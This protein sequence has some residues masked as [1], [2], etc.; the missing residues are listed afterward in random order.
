MTTTSDTAGLLGLVPVESVP[1]SDDS[2]SDILRALLK[3]VKRV[4]DTPLRA[5]G[6][7]R[8]SSV[9][10][11]EQGT[12]LEDQETRIHEYIQAQGW[13]EVSILAD[14]AQSGRTSNR[15]G[16]RRVERLVRRRKVDVVIVDRIDRISRNLF[17]LLRFIK[18]LNDHGVT[19]VSLRENVDF[20]TAWGQLVLYILGS[21]AEFYSSILAQEIR[22][23]RYYAAKAG[24]LSSTFRLGYCKGN[25]SECT[26]PNGPGYCPAFGGPNRGGAKIRVDHPVEREAVRLMFEWYAGGDC[27]DDDIARRLNAEV[28]VLPD[29]TEVRFRTKGVPGLH[30]PGPFDRDSVRTVLNNPIY[31]GFVTYAGSDGQGNKRRK[32]V[33][34]FAGLHPSIVELALFRRVQTIRCNRYH[35]SQSRRTN[36][37]TYPLSGLVFC[38]EYRRP[39]RGIS[40]EG[41]RFRYYSDKLCR[42]KLPKSEWHQPNVRAES[43]EEAVE[44]LVTQI[45]LPSAWR[46]RILAYLLYDEGTAEMEYEKFAIRDRLRRAVELYDAGYYTREQLARIDAECQRDLA[47]LVPTN[48]YAGQEAGALLENLPSLW[49]ALADEEKNSLYRLLLNGVYLRDK[50]IEGIESR[51]PF[52]Q[53]LAEAAARW[54]ERE[55]G[56]GVP[57]V[58]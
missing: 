50:T 4:T 52:R 12:S 48:T 38:A 41:G 35:R 29:G 14:P 8:V 46:E 47:D 28:F 32:P 37:R 27:S 25:C 5:V 17:A 34:I 39:M 45:Q 42:Q 2:V 11:L 53:I 21:L 3:G 44:A 55:G 56:D 15:P 30:P 16:L 36:A 7:T 6:M 20:S 9:M 26:D 33:E 54:A 49:Q 13:L 23:Q 40:A 57:P 1:P 10:Q 43:V 31:A 51:P 58:A 22:L 18:L 19:L 24:R